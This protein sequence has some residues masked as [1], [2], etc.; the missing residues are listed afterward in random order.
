M[1]EK[2]MLLQFRHVKEVY[3]IDFL[4]ITYLL[5]NLKA[6]RQDVY[7]CIHKMIYKNIIE[8]YEYSQCPYCNTDNIVECKSKIK[9]NHCSEVYIVD[10]I[11]ERLRIKVE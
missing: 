9:C 7:S 5:I 11:E 3:N 8:I 4:S 2:E 6:S 1:I 10:S